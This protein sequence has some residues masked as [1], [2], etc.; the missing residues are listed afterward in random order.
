MLTHCLLLQTFRESEM[1]KVVRLSNKTEK[2]CNSEKGVIIGS[3]FTHP[4]ISRLRETREIPAIGWCPRFPAQSSK[5]FTKLRDFLLGK[6]RLA[7]KRLKTRNVSVGARMAR[8]PTS[9]GTECNKNEQDCP[10]TIAQLKWYRIY[11]QGCRGTLG[12]LILIW[13]VEYSQRISTAF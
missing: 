2:A 3:L 4:G 9:I 7:S 12:Q 13:K 6:W 8:Q 11:Q 10:R 5:Y 1:S